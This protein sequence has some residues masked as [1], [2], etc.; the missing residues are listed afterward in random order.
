MDCIYPRFVYVTADKSKKLIG[1]NE[2]CFISTNRC[3]WKDSCDAPTN[4][5]M[6][7]M[8]SFEKGAPLKITNNYF[9]DK[10][11]DKDIISDLYLFLG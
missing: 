6:R 10:E 8:A 5:K 11:K 4:V 3:F 1:K 2:K 9:K 7:T